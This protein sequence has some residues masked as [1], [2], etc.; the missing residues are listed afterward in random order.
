[1]IAKYHG[2]K[3]SLAALRSRFPISIK[4]MDLP[5]LAKIAREL[6]FEPNAVRLEL[7]G[8]RVLRTPC[9][10]HWNM[11]HFVVL[12]K[13]SEKHINIVDPASGARRISMDVVDKSFTGIA[14]EL[15][16][17]SAFAPIHDKET[18]LR[19]RDFWRQV[20]GLKKYL[21]QLL[22][23]LGVVQA[24]ALLSPL[25][26]QTTVDQAIPGGDKDFLIALAIG[27]G[28][29]TL[30]NAVLFVLRGV[31]SM[32][33]G[34]SF[35]FRLNDN[36][37][38][39]LL[40]LPLSFFESRHIGDINSRFGSLESLK[41]FVGGNLI[42]V[43]LDG[44]AVFASLALML[45]YNT[46]LTILVVGVAA[47]DFCLRMIFFLR[48][49]ELTEDK[50]NAAARTNSNFMETIRAITGIKIFGRESHRQKLWR[51]LTTEQYNLDIRLGRWN[52]SLGGLRQV[53]S[54][55]E[56]TLVIAL[57]G[58]MII[59]GNFSVGML[60]AFI[61]YKGQFLGAVHGLFDKVAEFRMLRLH[62]ERLS[63]IALAR[64]EEEPGEDRLILNPQDVRGRLELKNIC[65]RYGIGEPYVLKDCCLDLLPGESV[66]L[67]GASGCG[68]T[69][70]MKVAIGL[71]DRDSGQILIDGIDTSRIGVKQ[72]RRFIGAVMQNDTLMSG[73]L[74]E[75]ICMFDPDADMK[76]I[77]ECARL[78]S[79][80]DEIRSMPMGYNSL[81]GDMG[82]SLSGGQKQ[83]VLL[84]RALYPN[85]KILFL[86]EATSHLDPN[87]EKLA[88]EAIR[89]LN[90]T[91]LIIAHRTETWETADRVISFVRTEEDRWEISEQFTS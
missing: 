37:L 50:I 54:G 41:S 20:I 80:H 13:I 56:N 89:K 2:H 72:Y 26:I 31:V 11:N 29:L 66:A 42:S 44:I 33:M 58:L 45:A 15:E 49:R 19:L 76:R 60:F 48:V 70:L 71:L 21:L 90:I 62:L 51:S 38:S 83:R 28:L 61:A 65:F 17:T 78:A 30:F 47:G 59:G 32:H 87:N 81:I 75:N 55:L 1:M 69:T 23:L 9:I 77:A 4:G 46:S 7:E 73:T 16:R 5:T 40:K 63:E 79:V 53:M 82:S 67:V 86:D 43:F 12:T 25:Y 64:P 74:A 3:T 27:F 34:I 14:L 57:A 24:F 88:S 39:H 36:L 91:R 68:K 8:L 10:L 18:P 22:L 35:S 6:Q 85:P 84:A 52:M